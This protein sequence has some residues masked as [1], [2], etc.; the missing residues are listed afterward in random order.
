[1]IALENI[2]IQKIQLKVTIK[3]ALIIILNT[4]KINYDEIENIYIYCDEHTTATNGKYELKEGLLQEFK[5]GTYN[6]D[7]NKYFAPIFPKLKCINLNFCKSEKNI[8][9]RSSDIIANRI[10]H[11]VNKNPNTRFDMPNLYIKYLP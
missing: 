2:V 10:Y 4:K 1:M 5:Y 3:N 7:F 11:F 9:I 6:Y 8:L